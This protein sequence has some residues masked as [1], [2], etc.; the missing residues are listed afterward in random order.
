VILTTYALAKVTPSSAKAPRIKTFRIK[1][2]KK[3]NFSYTL[4]INVLQKNVTSDAC[5]KDNGYIS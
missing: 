4:Y 2:F 1:G 5:K 3:K